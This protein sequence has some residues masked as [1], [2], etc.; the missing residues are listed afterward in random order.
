MPVV[1]VYIS[2]WG[3]ACTFN[4]LLLLRFG[5]AGRLCYDGDTL[6]VTVRW[7]GFLTLFSNMKLNCP[8]IL[9]RLK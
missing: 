1:S 7:L 8:N 6:E 4:K 3:E 9:E 5:P 2:V